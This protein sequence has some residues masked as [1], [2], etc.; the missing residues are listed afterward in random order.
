MTT[1]DCSVAQQGFYAGP[2]HVI[3]SIVRKSETRYAKPE[4][5][6]LKLRDA[7]ES[8]TTDVMSNVSDGKSQDIRETVLSILSDEKFVPQIERNIREQGSDACK[9]VRETLRVL[10]EAFDKVNS[11]YIRSRKD[12]VRGVANE[13]IAN[14]EGRDGGPDEH[15]AICADEISPA[16]L[17][18]IDEALIGGM[19]TVKGSPNSHVA[20]L[21]ESIGVPYV[22][23]N[24][25][26][27]AQVWHAS[28]VIIDADGAKGTVI[29]DPDESEKQIALERMRQLRGKHDDEYADASVEDGTPTR[30]RTRIYANI[31]SPQDI[32]DLL[33]SG[34]DGVGLFRTEFLFLGRDEAPTEEE[35]YRAYTAVLEAMKGKEVIIRTMD[36]GSDKKVPYLNFVQE[37]NPALGLRGARVSLEWKEQ[38][39]PQLRALLRAGVLGNLKV[40]FPMITSDWEIDELVGLLHSVAEELEKEGV[41]F[42]IPQL[43][44]MVETPA[45][46]LCAQSLADKVSFFSIGTNDLTQYTL[47]LDREADGLGRYFNPHHDA[48][49]KLIEMTVEGGNRHGVV[50]GV[51]GQLA[52]DPDAVERLIEAGVDELSVPV[53]KVRQTRKLAAE[54]ERNLAQKA[55]ALHHDEREDVDYAVGA[56]ADGELIPMAEI[57]DPV[58][59]GGSMGE[60]FGVMP[61]NG[62]VYAPVSG[63]ILDIARTGHAIT[64]EQDD[65][66]KILV[67]VG[68]DTVNLGGKAFTLH[69]SSGSRVKM[70]RL[71]LEADLDMIEKAGFSPMVV[72]VA[73]KD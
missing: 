46:A 48:I 30:C 50:T 11:E 8:L 51:C 29:A 53:H 59:A 49:F 34:A 41:D 71:L 60:C 40:M 32:D 44:I 1:F 45:A 39:R 18:S 2:V 23:G 10:E 72:V 6:L 19:I 20:I 67:H 55:E 25:D 21:A 37:S 4:E 9:A 31:K 68:I 36:I 38:F 47:A 69:V 35:Q 62:C 3:D 33:A 26:A 24:A 65:G 63:V 15:C 16:Q 42:R 52:A 56:P 27:V 54:A 22:Y 43:G 70:G 5:E 12:D 17:A 14:I 64:I 73:L 66:R 7:V 57:P 13:I 58:F 61:K 28:F